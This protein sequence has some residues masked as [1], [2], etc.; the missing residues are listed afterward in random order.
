MHFQNSR[1][2]IKDQWASHPDTLERVR[3][4]EQLNIPSG[5]QQ[6]QPAVTILQQRQQHE[7]A[8]TEIMFAGV[9][10][11]GEVKYIDSKTFGE[12][13]NSLLRDI[14]YHE[15]FN[16][17]YDRKDPQLPKD[18]RMKG[19]V[20]DVSTL[21][22]DDKVE[23]VFESITLQNDIDTLGQI[24]RL[25][26]ET[27]TF[28]Y[29][30]EKFNAADAS[31]LILQLQKELEQVNRKIDE[32]D[33]LIYNHFLSLARLRGDGERFAQ[34]FNNLQGIDKA[35]EEYF[36]AYYELRG[37]A[38]FMSYELPYEEIEKG[39]GTMKEAEAKFRVQLAALLADPYFQFSIH[40]ER[41]KIFTDYLEKDRTYFTRPQ[42]DEEALAFYYSAMNECYDVLVETRSNAKREILDTMQKLETAV[43]KA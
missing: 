2:V 27:K 40:D 3:A 35:N 43:E 18:L 25:E 7:E 29:N 31:G 16:H 14:P 17:Y 11:E 32:N 4:L 28:D 20:S 38:S 12:A 23:A 5:S 6:D 21:F 33:L 19:D 36:R 8:L 39:M 9:N 34:L 10:Y 41:R 13:Y 42:Y 30:G 26:I 37:A 15:M 1:I 22:G 24:S